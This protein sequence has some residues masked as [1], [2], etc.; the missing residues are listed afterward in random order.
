VTE[1]ELE[2]RITK[3]EDIHEIQN[4]QAKY[5]YYLQRG[6][7]A[8]WDEMVDLFTDD[9]TCEIMDSGVHTGKAGVVNLYK[10]AKLRLHAPGL[11]GIVMQIQPY[12]EI[13]GDTAKGVW[14]G[15]GFVVHAQAKLGAAGSVEEKVA[16]WHHGR[17]ENEYRK[18]NGEW[19][20][21]KSHFRLVFQTPYSAEN[22]WVSHPVDSTVEQQFRDMGLNFTTPTGKPT[23]EHR[24]YN[25]LAR[26]TEDAMPDPILPPQ[27]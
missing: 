11:M 3:L 13:Y 23:T 4:L 9:C 22:G 8:N 2:A 19:K 15:F 10:E 24:P 5:G 6:S 18:V 20:I 27:A 14:Q 25:P 7:S 17:Y 16:S 1:T 12:I 26:T 21:A